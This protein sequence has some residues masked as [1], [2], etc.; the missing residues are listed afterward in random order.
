MS[1]SCRVLG[2]LAITTTPVVTDGDH[3]G[4]WSE[5]LQILFL[6]SGAV[7]ASRRDGGLQAW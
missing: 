2:M 7:A 1:I 4:R 5:S 6:P 3:A